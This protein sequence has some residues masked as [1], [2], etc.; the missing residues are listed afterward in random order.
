MAE[1]NS[2]KNELD[3]KRQCEL[4][5]R[6]IAERDEKIASL[7]S[8]LRYY[9][10]LSSVDPLTKLQNRRVLGNVHGYDSVIIGDIDFFKDIND[11]YGHNVGDMVLVEISSI[12]K[13]YVRDGDVVCRWGGEEFLILLKHCNLSNAAYKAG[14]LRL[15]IASLKEKFGFD[16]TMSFGVSEIGVRD[17][18]EAVAEADEAMY[19]S[20]TSGRNKVSVYT[21]KK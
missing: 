11:T 2:E 7:E 15:A 12:L 21:K 9:K 3:Y 18:K 16:I 1:V 19:K 5:L 17:L 14:Q 6:E 13:R 4:L 10:E 8:E 20:K